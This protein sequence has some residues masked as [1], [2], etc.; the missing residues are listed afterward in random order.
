MRL[1]NVG[2]RLWPGRDTFRGHPQVLT[3]HEQRPCLSAPSNA[4]A[5]ALG[6]GIGLALVCELV[7]IHGGSITAQS[8]PGAGTR[9]VVRIPSGREHLP[10]GQLSEEMAAVT[11]I[12]GQGTTVA[13][14]IPLL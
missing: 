2:W 13:G 8:A 11:S 6:T 9:M 14:Q 4:V 10:A 5:C 7:R 1:S 12:P 3:V